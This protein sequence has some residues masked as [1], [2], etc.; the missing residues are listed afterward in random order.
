MMFEI[1]ATPDFF[2]VLYMQW[3]V[4]EIYRRFGG[5]NTFVNETMKEKFGPTFTSNGFATYESNPIPWDGGLSPDCECPTGIYQAGFYDLSVG[6]SYVALTSGI[7]TIG[8]NAAI[9]TYKWDGINWILSELG[10]PRFLAPLG[11]SY[12]NGD[13]YY[14]AK[15]A[16]IVPNQD[17]IVVGSDGFA[18]NFDFGGISSVN[19]LPPS[20][21]T[22]IVKLGK[23]YE[24]YAENALPPY[25]QNVRTQR[26]LVSMEFDD[27]TIPNLGLELLVPFES[28]LVDKNYSVRYDLTGGGLIPNPIYDIYISPNE[29]WIT[30][31]TLKLIDGGYELGEYDYYYV[32][33][34]RNYASSSYDITPDKANWIELSAIPQT[35]LNYTYSA[36]QSS[37]KISYGPGVWMQT[38]FGGGNEGGSNMYV[39][40]HPLYTSGP[41]ARNPAMEF[42]VVS[43]VT[44]KS[45]YQSG[46]GT[47]TSG[48]NFTYGSGNDLV[49]NGILQEPESAHTTIQKVGQDLTTQ[50][51]T[52]TIDYYSERVNVP[53]RAERVPL[54]PNPVP[55]SWLLAG[56]V[57][58]TTTTLLD[59][60][61]ETDVPSYRIQMQGLGPETV[62]W[63]PGAFRIIQDSI[64]HVVDDRGSTMTRV[65]QVGNFDPIT[66]LPRVRV[67]YVGSTQDGVEGTEYRHLAT[68]TNYNSASWPIETRTAK[69]LNQRDA[70]NLVNT[71]NDP[72]SQLL[73]DCAPG[74]N[75]KSIA[76]PISGLSANYASNNLD[77]IA[78]F[79]W[80]QTTEGADP[81]SYSTS[82]E[83]LI[84]Q[85]TTMD[86][87]ATTGDL[88]S[89]TGSPQ[90]QMDNTT[91]ITTS[92]V[93][94]GIRGQPSAVAWNALPNNVA[95]LTAEDGMYGLNGTWDGVWNAKSLEVGFWETGN[96]TYDAS[97][98]HT[99][100]YSLKLTG[101]GNS[102]PY[103]SIGTK[104]YWLFGPTRNVYL[105]NVS[106]LRNG[107]TVSVWIYS[108]GI[109]PVLAIEQRQA[110]GTPVGEIRGCPVGGNFVPNCWQ[111]WKIFIPKSSLLAANFGTGMPM[112]T[113]DLIGMA[114][115]YLR[116]WVGFSTPIVNNTS[117]TG[118]L[119]VDDIVIAPSDARVTLQSYDYAGRVVGAID[120]DGHTSTIE[121]GPKGEV[122]A[123]RD[124]RGRIFNQNAVLQAE[125]K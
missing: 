58:S 38:Y 23:G 114:G 39:S 80:G 10:L 43:S 74:S 52:E 87:V 70:Q 64:T 19:L 76:T 115:D 72:M 86:Q 99:G 44:T 116:A 31:K 120:P 17:G 25:L 5:T 121:Y 95:V 67:S 78:A 18:D 102:Y 105:K 40:F 26:N 77:T 83:A 42:Q 79:R 63:A 22:S 30:G 59:G 122:Q 14:T 89:P 69:Y 1:Q 107:I 55:N 60:T 119:W 85:N 103:D 29:D 125:E 113:S 32:P 33:F 12:G 9:Y 50:F 93:Y 36:N 112:F 48:Y 106:N 108:T 111:Q 66:G 41:V 20:Q 35:W 97:M 8:P 34:P 54:Q 124:E 118:T 68:V 15:Q 7:S 96:A 57:K 81:N 104:F 49:Y 24:W 109:P 82:G 65:D 75:G 90:F 100:Q 61:L 117:S 84:P 6:N 110:D 56:Q 11:N 28:Y 13:D 94:E 21:P 98:A 2:A 91:N 47:V 73:S 51:S 71:V 46:K 3:S 4:V 53:L 16:A 45:L 101:S 27:P 88:R 37:P 92:Y 123:V 62:N